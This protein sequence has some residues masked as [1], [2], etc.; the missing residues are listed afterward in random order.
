MKTSVRELRDSMKRVLDCV[1][2]GEEVEVYLREKPIAKI[3]PI[4]K[5]SKVKEDY[6]FG[7]WSDRRDMKDVDQYVRGMRRGRSHDD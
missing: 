7:M 6:G 5:V 4:K 1:Q 3:I 2:H